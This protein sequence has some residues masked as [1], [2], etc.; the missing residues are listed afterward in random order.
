[1]GDEALGQ[2]DGGGISEILG[3]RGGNS[4]LGAT[5]AHLEVSSPGKRS[6]GLLVLHG[7]RSLKH[8]P[9][10]RIIKQQKS[11]GFLRSI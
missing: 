5:W 8:S 11:Q 10:P 2:G 4:I 7:N 6:S 1:M 3:A 9:T